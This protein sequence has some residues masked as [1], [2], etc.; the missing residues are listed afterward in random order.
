MHRRFHLLCFVVVLAAVALATQ[1]L[2]ST[3]P[4]QPPP[5]IDPSELHIHRES[6]GSGGEYFGF[7][8]R[9]CGESH[10]WKVFGYE[11]THAGRPYYFL[12]AKFDLAGR[13]TV[14]RGDSLGCGSDDPTK[15]WKALK[16]SGTL[17]SPVVLEGQDGHKLELYP[18]LGLAIH[19][20]SPEVVEYYLVEPANWDE[21]HIDDCE[22]LS[23]DK[24]RIY[25][26]P[27]L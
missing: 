16:A 14:V 19:H 27:E 20:L 23:H 9:Y 13:P 17:P 11:K 21:F 10:D 25:L 5:G 2:E 4:P 3:P 1:N 7:K 22:L 18:S 8:W 26:A 15:T 24:A 12:A 6:P